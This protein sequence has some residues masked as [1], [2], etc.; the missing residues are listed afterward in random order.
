MPKGTPRPIVDL[1]ARNIQEA[2]REPEFNAM[3][4]NSG[5]EVIGDTP[6]QFAKFIKDQIEVFGKIIKAADIKEPS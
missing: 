1:L 4:V 3:L 2:L 6:E 5:F